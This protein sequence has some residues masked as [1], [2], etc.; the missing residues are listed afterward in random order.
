MPISL[1]LMLL[2]TNAMSRVNFYLSWAASLCMRVVD[3]ELYG[4]DRCTSATGVLGLLPH[5]TW[6]LAPYHMSLPPL[7]LAASAAVCWPPRHCCCLWRLLFP[8]L[9]HL[10]QV[11]LVTQHLEH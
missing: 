7:L 9:A 3:R 4:S 1:L 8:L 11:E 5:H 2:L 6:W 10:S